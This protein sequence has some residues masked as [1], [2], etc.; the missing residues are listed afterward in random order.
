M[1]RRPTVPVGLRHRS[2]PAS[3]AAVTVAVT[4]AL[5]L[6]PSTSNAGNV[7]TGAAASAAQVRHRVV[8]DGLDNPRQLSLTHDG[9][10]VIAEAGHGSY[11]QKNCSGSGRSEL[12]VGLSGKVSVLADGEVRRVMTRLLSVAGADGS[13]ATGPDGAGKRPGGRFQAIMTYGPPEFFPEGIPGR[14]QT[15]KLVA[16]AGDRNRIIANVSRFEIN[17]D[18]DGEGVD[19]NPYSL[20]ALR[21]K[22]LVADAAGDYIAAVRRGGKIRLWATLP[23]YGARIDAVPTVVSLGGDGNVYVGE[24][25]SQIPK[26]ARVWKYDRRGNVLRSW[27]GFTTVTGVARTKNGTLYVSELFGG[28]CD[29][30]DCFPGRVVKVAPNGKRSSTNVPFPAGIVARGD[31]VLVSAFSISPAKG[32]AGNPAFSGQI[33]R[34]LF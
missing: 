31:R 24:L 15:G 10:V 3:A 14:R 8:V 7:A 21:N 16:G 13:F 18:P 27:G 20:L 1:Q 22:T 28:D 11:Q 23:E 29:G 25:H 2:A 12:C 33:W 19:S 5:L 30:D 9:R 34:L 6:S 32:F 17:R 26:E 4:A